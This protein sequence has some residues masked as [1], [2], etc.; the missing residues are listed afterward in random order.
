MRNISCILMYRVHYYVAKIDK[1]L[2]IDKKIHTFSMFFN[3]I[4]CLIQKKVVIL[5]G[6]SQNLSCCVLHRHCVMAD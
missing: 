2:H 6:I 3:I 4:L 5:S 1:I